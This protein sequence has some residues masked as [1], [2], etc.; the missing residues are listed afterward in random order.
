[1][2][3][4]SLSGGA[5]NFNFSGGSG[6]G[7]GGGG[8]D[9]NIPQE[10]QLEEIPQ[11]TSQV[12]GSATNTISDFFSSI[13]TA[14]W[15]IL[16][17]TIL[18]AIL[19]AVAISFFIREWARG[20]LIASIHDIEDQKNPSLSQ[21]SKHGL[22]F[23]AR[24]IKLH[25]FPGLLYFIFIS[26]VFAIFLV[27]L[28]L[29]KAQIAKIII[30][31]IGAIIFLPALL[32]GGILLVL[33]IIISE[34]LIV[35]KDFAYRQALFSAFKLVKKYVF[36]MIGLAAIHLGL[37]CAVGCAVMVLIGIL[38]AIIG[39]AFVI[40]KQVGIA[41]AVLIGIP[42]IILILLSILIQGI[43][44]VFKTSNWTLLTRQIEELEA[45]K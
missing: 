34:Q 25:I 7:G 15:L 17:V 36:Q 23:V 14:Y 13:P 18:L 40:K 33:T 22:R 16:A 35:K 30:A 2:V 12:L 44:L 3:L 10:F 31:V 45:K 39:V 43:L 11:Q 5:N 27:L 21:G 6:S 1:M 24:L 38:A 19:I 37:G 42:F 29:I 9:V 41:M 8:D 20:A 4:A 28:I 32:V 26:L